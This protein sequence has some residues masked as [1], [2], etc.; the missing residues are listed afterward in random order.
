MGIFVFALFVLVEFISGCGT[1]GKPGSID[2]PLARILMLE[3]KLSFVAPK[4]NP[5]L[6]LLYLEEKKVKR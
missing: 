6:A 1:V 2:L 5:G 3:I 4:R